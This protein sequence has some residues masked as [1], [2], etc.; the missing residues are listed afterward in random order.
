M[1]NKEVG[2][3]LADARRQTAEIT[4]ISELGSLLQACTSQ[5]E[6]F[7]LIPERLRR[8]FPGASVAQ[9]SEKAEADL[10]RSLEIKPSFASAL[11]NLA[12]VA[13]EKGDP[14]RATELL[15]QFINE[16][17][18]LPLFYRGERLIAAYI[19]R[20]CAR[21]KGLTDAPA[22]E[23][24]T[25]IA[26]VLKDC[27]AACEEGKLY[28]VSDYFEDCLQRNS[29]EGAELHPLESLAPEALKAL[30]NRDCSDRTNLRT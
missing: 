29:I 28:A 3:L 17:E 27:R 21:A 13:D 24:G 10:S 18:N 7:R 19:N 11:F 25:L 2:R 26:E 30:Q 20:A 22:N 23:Q 9:K 16:R 15:T 4:E 8:L 6:V 12:W 1:S 5:A 14:G